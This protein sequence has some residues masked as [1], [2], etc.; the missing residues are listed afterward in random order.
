MG[1]AMPQVA[2]QYARGQSLPVEYGISSHKEWLGG[3][4]GRLSLTRI[5]DGDAVAV[6]R[7]TPGE[8]GAKG[9]SLGFGRF[10]FDNEI[11]MV[12]GEF[13]LFFCFHSYRLT[14]G[15]S[16]W[17]K[18]AAN[19]KGLHDCKPCSTG[20]PRWVWNRRARFYAAD[21]ATSI[22]AAMQTQCKT[23]SVCC[24]KNSTFN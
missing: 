22:I 9:Y 24:G 17:R 1:L 16:S 3:W 4:P 7:V 5:I 2:F 8:E 15:W 19:E 23:S 6:M 14:D 21:F 18:A 11:G 20:V 10:V 13:F 12:L